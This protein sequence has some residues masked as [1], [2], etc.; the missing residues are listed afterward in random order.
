LAGVPEHPQRTACKK[1]L[2]AGNGGIANFNADI[3]TLCPYE[4]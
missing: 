1:G 4:A 3:C 2:A